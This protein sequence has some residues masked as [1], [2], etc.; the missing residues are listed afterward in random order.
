MHVAVWHDVAV[1]FVVLRVG[2]CVALGPVYIAVPLVVTY[3][4][5][6]GG[7]PFRPFPNCSN[8]ARRKNSHWP[9]FNFSP[10]WLAQLP[11]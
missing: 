8:I 11:S 4:T 1:L 7:A 5:T 3:V 2:V 9:S 10:R 6:N